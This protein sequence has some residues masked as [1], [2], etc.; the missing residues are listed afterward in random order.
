MNRILNISGECQMKFSFALVVLVTTG[1]LTGCASHSAKTI[2]GLDNNDPTFNSS[3]CESARANAWVHDTTQKNKLW[4]GPS[5]IWLAG[6]VALVPMFVTNVG[7]NTADK[8]QANDIAAQCGGKPQSQAQ[9]S[10][11]IA[12]DASLSLAAGAIVP[13]T[14]PKLT[15]P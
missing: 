8:L 9:M 3:A 5:F 2:A 6:P 14:I 7:L 12:L 15:P 13:V 4:V 11:D 1:F 10:A